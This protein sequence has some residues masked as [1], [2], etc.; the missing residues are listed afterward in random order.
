MIARETWNNSQG[1]NLPVQNWR[2]EL[3]T[4]TF[5]HN[6]VDESLLKQ[7]DMSG[8]L[9][10]SPEKY[11]FIAGAGSCWLLNVSLDTPKILLLLV[12]LEITSQ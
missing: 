5:N 11:Q 3:S 12:R 9:K 2:E 8:T 4:W 6:I 1:G 10:I 7:R